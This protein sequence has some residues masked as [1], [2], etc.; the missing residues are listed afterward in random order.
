MLALSTQSIQLLDSGINPVG[1]I[2]A[3]GDPQGTYPYVS[4]CETFA[5]PQLKRYQA[6]VLENKY[7]RATIIP[8]LGGR[9][10]SLILKKTGREVLA[11]HPI[12]RPVRILPRMAFA[13]GG[14]E[15]SFPISHTP[16]QLE[17]LHWQTRETPDRIYCFCGER[18]IYCGMLY[19][20]EFSLGA[21]DEFL[22][23]RVRIKNPTASSHPW[24]SWSNA[25]VPAPQDAIIDYP[26]GPVLCHNSTLSRIERWETEGVQRQDQLK[27]MT[28][29]FWE[30]PPR[31]V[32]GVFSPSRQLGL[33]HL[34]DVKQVPGIKFWS[35][36]VGQD[37]KWATDSQLTTD[38][39]LEMQ[40]GPLGDQSI[41][42]DLEPNEERSWTSFWLPVTER[43]DITQIQIPEP[44]FMPVSSIPFFDWPI[45]AQQWCQSSAEGRLK[46]ELY[47]VD[48][49]LCSGQKVPPVSM[50]HLQ[51][52]LR[53]D[54]D[55]ASPAQQEVIAALYGCLLAAKGEHSE[56]LVWLE[57]SSLDWA[58]LL[59][60][61]I[62]R[63]FLKQPQQAVDA[64]S[65]INAKAYLA[66]PQVTSEHIAALKAIGQMTLDQQKE[67]LQANNALPD[68]ELI[69]LRAQ[70]DLDDNRPNDA[71]KHLQ[72]HAFQ[73]V[74]QTYSNTQLYKAV[75]G[76]LGTY[77]PNQLDDY[78][79]QVGED[80]LA[81]WG[82]YRTWDTE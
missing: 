31:S 34:A 65:K 24:M 63:V 4:Y 9:L 6:I 3:L 7:L 18:E 78:A 12:V 25:A 79:Q 16:M 35:Y 74:H 17:A 52:T 43:Q 45:M 10:F 71:L 59:E 26:S 36:G 76:Q 21:D 27:K 32:F 44:T 66:H 48:E 67:V 53:A 28:G 56:S 47:T 54:Y 72:E 75:L 33:Y 29:L 23:Q 11:A 38:P 14:L 81:V 64:L 39:Y 77:D 61:R 55:L 37:E 70:L 82:A 68:D 50:P 58:R 42:H 20:L 2:P 13:S 19:T 40:S 49:A 80:K 8:A 46:S 22:S 62:H 41:K 69:A 1:P 73:R 15:V 60:A 57:R 51:E 30:A 5:R